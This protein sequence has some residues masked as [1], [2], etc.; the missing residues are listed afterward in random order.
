MPAERKDL[1]T[2]K[3]RIYESLLPAAGDTR[4]A[5][6][7]AGYAKSVSP[8]GTWKD[9]DYRSRQP[10]SW[11]TAGHLRR[12]RVMAGALRQP[13]GKM[14]GNAGLKAAT[15]RA[16]DHWLKK[17][18]RN[19]NWWWNEIGV[20]MYLGHVLALTDRD[21][22]PAQ[23]A[24]GVKIMKRSKIGKTGQNLVW[25]AGNQV[26]WGCLAGDAKALE[27]AFKRMAAEI[28][29]AG[30]DR[31]GVK[32]DWSFWQHGRCLYSGGYGK[33]FSRDGAYFA[34][35][36]GGTRFAFAPER[37]RILSSY[38]L[39]GQQ[40]T[41]RGRA[42]DYGTIGREI[43]R[44]GAGRT[45][46]L[47]QACRY[48]L[49]TKPPREKELADLL[50]RLEN[51]PEKA[52]APLVGNRHYW[53]SD[54][55]VHHRKS[56]YASARMFSTRLDNTDNPCN[57]EGLLSHHIAD[58]AN[59]VMRRGDEYAGV[60][61]VWNWRLVP[62]ITAE[63][64]EG[65]LRGTP[66]SRGKGAFVGGVS[67]GEYGAAAMQ[68][69]RGKLSARKAWF[70][71]DREY[72]CLG[73]G[74]TCAS[75]TP[76]V[77]SVNQCLLKGDVIAS[78]KKLAAG[79]HRPTVPGWVHHDGV[80]YAFGKGSRPVLRFGEQGGSWHRLRKASPK[81][82]VK[83]DVFNLRLEH[84]A[85]PKNGTYSYVVAPAIPAGE[86]PAYA[87]GAG[88]EVLSNRPDLQAVLH[89]GLGIVGAVFAK[90]GTVKAGDGLS[91]TADKP[92]LLLVR[93]R[94]R[95]RVTA[96]NPLNGPLKVKVTVSVPGGTPR[97]FTLDLPS[98]E[99]AGSS[100]TL[101]APK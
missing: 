21:L 44:S 85:G 70:F 38:I 83:L 66:R 75:Q 101:P 98:G 43:S 45:G 58:G 36:A 32:A 13:G 79:E 81:T 35:L 10:S 92:C 63:Q 67:D 2:V 29:V 46:A 82:P 14:A 4:A 53:K 90:P 11:P 40:W 25:L 97:T 57:S 61:P 9:V 23:R 86:M 71:F 50:D 34:W 89:T 19:P 12:L 17:D 60:F 28:K 7:A 88:V 49:K 54:F 48:M 64:P 6:R 95:L 31:E 15:L 51:G 77:T 78:G 39:D 1:D 41:V 22:T 52:R 74:I 84:G 20:P 99:K 56:W 3:Q 27:T 100:V 55:T 24:A 96:S 94:P 93:T 59:F 73:A 47:I 91:I 16:L 30:G 42:L 69:A 80:G 33:G 8:E 68:L 62:G 26:V 5:G 18:Y 87:K 72:A 37:I 76:V 65:R